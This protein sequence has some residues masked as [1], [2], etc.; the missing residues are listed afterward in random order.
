MAKRP[1]QEGDIVSL[2][3]RVVKALDGTVTLQIG[4]QRVTLPED[5]EQIEMIVS[6]GSHERPRKL[7]DKPD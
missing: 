3:A 7:Y 5:S 6:R 4:T 2:H 1:I